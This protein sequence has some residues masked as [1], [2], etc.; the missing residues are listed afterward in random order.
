[1][2]N[3]CGP[4]VLFYLDG[5]HRGERVLEYCS[6]IFRKGPG[7]CT[8]VLDDIHWSLDMFRAWKQLISREGDQLSIEL[9][10]LGILIRGYGVQNEHYVV[11][12]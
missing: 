1:M 11:K 3:K 9:D 10:N 4:G 8:L 6:L 2:V 7:R 5:D 12:F